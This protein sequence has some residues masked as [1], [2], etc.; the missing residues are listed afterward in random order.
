MKKNITPSDCKSMFSDKLNSL[1]MKELGIE[2]KH[3]AIG[4]APEYPS[5]LVNQDDLKKMLIDKFSNFF[6]P[7]RSQGLEVI[8]LRSNYG[9][10]KSHF[11]RTIH[12]FLNNFEN[13]LAKRVSLKQEKTDLKIKILEG[14][15]QKTIKESAVFFVDMAASESLA[16]E[17][18][19][20]LLTLS[21]KLNVNTALCELLYQAARSQDISKQ[22]QAIALLKGNYMPTYLK[23]FGLKRAD[24]NNEFYF[25]II[26]L[27]CD[28]LYESNNYMVIVFDEYEHVYSWKD[29][30]ARKV[31]FEDI[32]LFTDNLD[33]YKNLFFVFAESESVD[34]DSEASDDPAY[35]S[36]KKGRTYQ[37]KNISSEMEVQKLFKMIKSR[38]EK[39]YEVSLD[40]YV[41]EILE[42]IKN[43]EQVKANSNY[44]NYTQVIMRILDEYKNHPVK[45]RRSTK[46]RNNT[47][48]VQESTCN[49][50]NGEVSFND[51]WKAANSISKKTI[52]CEAIEYLL[53][54][55]D[56]KILN[57]RKKQGIYLTQKQQEK[58]EYHI[59]ATQ[60]PSSSDFI[61]RYNE[62]LRIQSENSIDRIVILYP[63][64]HD[65]NNE[66]KYEN[67]IFYD[68]N[69]VPS[70]LK[71][72]YANEDI[73]EDVYSYLMALESGC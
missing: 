18:E 59:I 50:I 44:R 39:Y 29:A 63:Y 42:E 61:K 66:F 73:I 11:I 72:I 14:V 69:R 37:I 32:K 24:V 2:L 34:N 48:L 40:E 47:K 9:N 57:K 15:G 58:I 71:Q 54:H 41:D 25:D 21:E 53:E 12:S 62:I 26:R 64:Q 30:Q 5:Y 33:T 38:Y 45:V 3:F 19:A 1:N 8:F 68:V 17:K 7:N 4:T 51:K 31:F 13:V 49:P 56:E 46:A 60:N 23:T 10:G 16:D 28:F 20:I 52:L 43:D 70:V 6:D 27:I 22:S 65:T 36:R 67:V 55:S 35:V